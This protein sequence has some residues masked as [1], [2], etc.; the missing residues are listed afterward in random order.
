MKIID[1]TVQKSYINEFRNKIKV[2]TKTYLHLGSGVCMGASAYYLKNKLR[3]KGN[4]WEWLSD[5]DNKFAVIAPYLNDDYNMLPPL[6]ASN[7]I[8]KFL[9]NVLES[10]ITYAVDRNWLP[11]LYS[12][13]TK[14]KQGKV[15]RFC[16]FTSGE[17]GP[18]HAIA[19]INYQ[20]PRLMDPNIGEIEF[21]DDND[22]YSWLLANWQS[23]YEKYHSANVFV[24]A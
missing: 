20:R 18:A 2:P 8:N 7:N 21:D 14:L 24:Y 23:N 9:K 19:F 1:S 11:D 22:F 10:K 4:F 6:V 5:F 16:V 15:G 3:D 17:Q 12:A 13:L